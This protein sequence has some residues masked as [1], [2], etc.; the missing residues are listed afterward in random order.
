MEDGIEYYLRSS[1]SNSKENPR[2]QQLR[3]DIRRLNKHQ[4]RKSN[5]GIAGDGNISYT[6]TIRYQTPDGAGDQGD[7]FIDE[8]K[9]A[10]NVTNAMLDADQVGDDKGYAAVEEDEEGYAE[11]GDTQE[12]GQSL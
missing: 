5:D 12:V 11:E 4:Q 6:D 1:G 9:S 10:D 2:Q 3:I 8:A 7:D